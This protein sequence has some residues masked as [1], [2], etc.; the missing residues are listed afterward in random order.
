MVMHA[1]M[2]ASE[3]DPD[4]DAMLNT[5]HKSHTLSYRHF[6]FHKF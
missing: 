4:Y 5:G 6:H 3:E 1:V 2:G